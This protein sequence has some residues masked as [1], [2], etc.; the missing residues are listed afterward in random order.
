MRK[1]LSLFGSAIFLIVAPGT[2]AGFGPWWIGHW[3]VLPSFFGYSS[4]REL[5]IFLAVAGLIPLLESFV[6]FALEGLGTPA[7]IAPP[8]HL[9]V[10][11]FY[12]HV[13]NP[14]YVGVVAIVLG[15]ALYFADQRILA[16]AAIVWLAFHA[17]VVGYEEPTLRELFGGA[18]DEFCTNVPRWLPRITPWRQ[19]SATGDLNL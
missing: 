15:Q 3:T 8:K 18:Y 13:R 12:R 11:G 10:G 9:V 1:S 2:I 14:M 16:Y 7:P 17:F 6:R 5:G 4:L 19:P